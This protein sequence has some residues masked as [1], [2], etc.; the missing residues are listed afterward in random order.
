[1]SLIALTML[2]LLIFHEAKNTVAKVIT[3]PR[4]NEVSALINET[5]PLRLK[6]FVLPENI[7][8]ATTIK[9][10]P[11]PIPAKTPIIADPR[12]YIAPSNM[13]SLISC[14][15]C[16]PTALAIPISLFRSA[17]NIENIKK[18]SKSPTPIENKPKVVKNVTNKLPILFANSTR[19]AFIG[20]SFSP[21]DFKTSESPSLSSIPSEYLT[22]SYGSPL[23][24]MRTPDRKPSSPNRS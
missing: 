8:D 21:F 18:I 14:C 5:F 23:F 4:R 19:S 15:L 17:A 10:R 6:S 1:M 7:F 24:V 13:K 9:R 20:T 3:A 11:I 2:R 16:I 12:P 22:P